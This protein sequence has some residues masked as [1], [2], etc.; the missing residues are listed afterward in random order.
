MIKPLFQKVVVGYDGSKTSLHAVLYAILMAKVYRC[1]VKVVCVV[2]TASIKQLTLSKFMVADEAQ[3]LSQNLEA[4]GRKN[5]D[6]VADIAK[7]KGVKIE[8][9]L[10]F[11]SVW[12]EIIKAADEFKADVILLGG[13]DEDN[14]NLCHKNISSRDSEIIGS[15]HCS[16]LVVREPY[17]EQ[18]FRLV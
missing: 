17:I 14:S 7:K 15:A 11:G 2:D 18:K 3:V 9:Q 4:D 5:L 13:A 12:S 8:T 10:C 16:V 6:Y 1:D